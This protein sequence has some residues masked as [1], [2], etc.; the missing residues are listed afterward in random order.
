MKVKVLF[1]GGKLHYMNKTFLRQMFD[2]EGKKLLT[3]FEIV[4]PTFSDD[5]FRDICEVGE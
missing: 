4:F 5:F 3:E 1:V 2:T